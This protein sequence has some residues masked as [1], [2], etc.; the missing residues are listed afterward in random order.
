MFLP[1]II[2]QHLPQQ[3]YD[4]DQIGRSQAQVLLYEDR[5]LKI[6]KDGNCS[7]NEHAMMRYLQGKLEVPRIIAADKAGD[8]RYLL[9]SRIPGRYL[10]AE[11]ILD[12]QEELAMLVAQAL[13]RMWQ[14]DIT[15]CPTDRSLNVKFREIEEGL[16]LGTITKEYARQEETYGPGGFSSPA[17]LF[18]WL[19]KK[20]PDEQLALSHGDFC[21]PNVFCD[22]QGITGYI[23]LG[24]AGMAD[25]WVD[26]EQV[27]WSMWANTTGQFGGKVRPFDRRLLFDA[28]NMELDEE[29]LR[30]YSLL[31]ELC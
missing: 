9:M 3:A 4:Q 2:K 17:A 12:D 24:C 28:L 20:R 23:D 21:L 25:P 7:A 8:M 27:L 22:N 16:L 5:V 6:E 13:R 10:C 30:Y 26:I 19:V 29:K 1:N 11:D 15:G 18:D 31:S 14:V